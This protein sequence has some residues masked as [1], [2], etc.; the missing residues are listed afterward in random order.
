MQLFETPLSK[1][2]IA[3]GARMVSFAGWSMPVQYPAGILKEHR[4]CRA[5]V[6]LFD[7]CHMGEFRVTGPEA[8]TALDP[9]FARSVADQPVGACRYNLLMDPSGGIRDDLIVYR[10][11]PEEF[12]LVVNAGTCGEDAVWLQDHLPSAVTFRDESETTGKLDLQGPGSAETLERL[13][14]PGATLPSYYHWREATLSG[15][16]ILLSRTG[17][18]GEL[19]YE[20]Y[21]PRDR[22][23]RLWTRFL[24][25]EEVQPAGL[26]ARDTLRL[27]MG[28]PLYGHEID[29]DT[30][31]VEAGLPYDKDRKRTFF[32]DCFRERTPRKQRTGLLLSGRRAARRGDP[33]FSEGQKRIGSITSGSFAPSLDRSAALSYIERGTRQSPGT[34][35]L[36]GDR[37]NPLHAEVVPLP[38]YRKGTAGIQLQ[39]EQNR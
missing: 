3:L 20:I 2:H 15:E 30:T 39:E 1:N 26:G 28:F 36:I 35:V 19:G 11:N 23:V 13:G 6:S 37:K 8:A 38:F 31:P 17:Y 32:G 21:L 9:L 7:T 4:H 12:F 5:A 25:E 24:A 22:T 18:T 29:L 34:K 10:I 33:V 27:E 14:L 16:K